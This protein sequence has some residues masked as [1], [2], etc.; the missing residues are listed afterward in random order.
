MAW[1]GVLNFGS[2]AV[3]GASGL[4][5]GLTAMVNW[6][7]NVRA[8]VSLCVDVPET[9]AI[10][11]IGV[12]GDPDLYGASQLSGEVTFIAAGT[13]ATAGVGGVTEDVT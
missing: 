8:G 11:Q 4:V 5:N 9:P 1:H 13:V 2:G 7:N 10:P 12:W 3:N 6:G